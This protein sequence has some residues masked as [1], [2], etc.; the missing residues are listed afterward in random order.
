MVGTDTE[1]KKGMLVLAFALYDSGRHNCVLR[2]M[3]YEDVAAHI[4][5]LD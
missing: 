1:I 4:R 2:S 5:L 3:V